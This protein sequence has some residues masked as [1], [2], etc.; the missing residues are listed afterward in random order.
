MNY[1]VCLITKN[2]SLKNNVI[3]IITVCIYQFY[4]LR[5]KYTIKKNNKNWR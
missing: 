1:F 4:D 2:K 5:I 3:L